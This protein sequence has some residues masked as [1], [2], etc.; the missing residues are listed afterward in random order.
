MTKSLMASSINEKRKQKY[1]LILKAVSVRKSSELSAV[2]SEMGI[3][4]LWV[5]FLLLPWRAPLAKDH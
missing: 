5:L 4:Y 1:L 3:E 2:N